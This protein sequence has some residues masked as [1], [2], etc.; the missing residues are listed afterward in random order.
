M[1]SS[2]EYITCLYRASL[3]MDLDVHH[4][5]KKKLFDRLATLERDLDWLFDINLRTICYR[6]FDFFIFSNIF[7]YQMLNIVFVNIGAFLSEA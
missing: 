6:C 3:D 2:V 4:D 5:G 1:A 7:R